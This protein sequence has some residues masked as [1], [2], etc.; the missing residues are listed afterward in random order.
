MDFDT[1]PVTTP[2]HEPDLFAATDSIVLPLTADQAAVQ[3]E[4]DRQA[5]LKEHIIVDPDLYDE[6][7]SELITCSGS[8]ALQQNQSTQAHQLPWAHSNLDHWVI[9][10]EEYFS[11]RGKPQLEGGYTRVSQIL[12]ARPESQHE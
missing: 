4:A 7:E 8:T 10:D 12:V 9:F 1:P 2:Y 11:H 5:R 3:E 6:D